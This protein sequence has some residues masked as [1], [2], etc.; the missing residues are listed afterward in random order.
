[1]STAS[2]LNADLHL[3]GALTRRA[4]RRSMETFQNVMLFRKF[5]GTG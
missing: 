5:E 2:D 4:D 1:M 3:H